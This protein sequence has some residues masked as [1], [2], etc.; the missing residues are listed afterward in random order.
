V[1]E[2][3]SE[4][5]TRREILRKNLEEALPHEGK[6]ARQNHWL[7]LALMFL[8]LPCSTLASFATLIPLPKWLIVILPLLPGALALAAITF[9]PQD[10]A[11]WHYRKLNGLKALIHK[12]DFELPEV[13]GIADVATVSR[14]LTDLTVALQKE[15]E[16]SMSLNWK[17][18]LT[19]TSG[20]K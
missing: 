13:P 10:R 2:T 18:F 17:P 14:E 20:T 6:R 4:T 12:L 8:I 16:N 7:A 19:S 15:W 9:R 3:N 5:N 1:A 11:N